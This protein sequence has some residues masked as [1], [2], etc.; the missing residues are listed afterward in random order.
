MR[1]KIL[2]ERARE[3][4]KQQSEPEIRMWLA[5]RAKRFEAT[6]FRRQKVIGRY[7]ADFASRSPML[8][9]E[10]D[11]ESHGHQGEYDASRTAYLELQGYRVIRFSNVEVMENLDGVLE[12]LWHILQTSPLP[13]L[14]PEGER[15]L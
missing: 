4:R 2:T 13:T 11:G 1:D 5:L 14:P 12:T 8:V 10:L 9:I 6:K 3:M 7:I 15:A